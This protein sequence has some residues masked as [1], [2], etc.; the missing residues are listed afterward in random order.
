M[1]ETINNV[2]WA[3]V[4]ILMVF[5]FFFSMSEKWLARNKKRIQYTFIGTVCLI[6]ATMP[7]TLPHKEMKDLKA[8]V[9]E[10][11]VKAYRISLDMGKVYR[12]NIETRTMLNNLILQQGK[13]RQR[14]NLILDMEYYKVLNSLDK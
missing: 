7:F 8:T 1:V 14:V 12:D 3:A 4:L 13:L 2:S 6:L 10:S 9:K 11:N 5:I